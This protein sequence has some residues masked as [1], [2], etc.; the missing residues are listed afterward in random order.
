MSGYKY[1]S[2]KH[3]EDADD[4]GEFFVP[5]SFLLR[6]LVGSNILWLGGT[7]LFSCGAGLDGWIRVIRYLIFPPSLPH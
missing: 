7:W 6:S 2:L 5:S 1:D 3:A 4:H